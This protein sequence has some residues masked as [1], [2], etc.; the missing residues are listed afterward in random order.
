MRS[1][2][3]IGA[4]QAGLQL[5][6]GLAKQGYEV[7]IVSDRSAEEVRSGRI[8]STQCMFA[9][10]LS[11]EREL[12]LNFWEQECPAIPG[13]RF[14]VASPQTG[15]LDLVIWGELDDYAQSVDQR[16]KMSGWLEE[17]ERLGGNLMLSSA[18]LDLLDELTGT[19]DLTLVA[20]GKGEIG[21]LFEID[22]TRTPYEGPQRQLV[23]LY[24]NGYEDLDPP[25]FAISIVPGVGEYF[26]GPALTLSGPCHTMCFEA[27]PGG[28]MDQWRDPELR[29]APERLLATCKQVLEEHFP[30]EA[31][32]A[33]SVELTDQQGTLAGGIPPLVR[34]AVAELRSG[35]PVMGVGDAVVLN[36]PLVGQGANNAC[37]SAMIVLERILDRGDRPFDIE[38]MNDTAARVWDYV[39]WPTEYTNTMLSPPQHIGALLAAGAQD[40]G[41]ADALA[42]ATNDPSTLLPEIRTGEGTRELID[43]LSTQSSASRG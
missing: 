16:L 23:A 9:D 7:T 31:E 2:A 6:L 36:D 22:P 24:V 25:Y 28:P 21:A 4:G 15:D 40:Q 10:A 3:V 11:A 34:H 42:N 27:I 12:G 41:V 30:W 18:D 38:W 39:K 17:L 1:I 5:A 33:A 37:R 13:V 29:A 14:N 35:R 32:R 19:H 20:A 43:R 8:M 26:V